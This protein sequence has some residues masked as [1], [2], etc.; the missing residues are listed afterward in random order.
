MK[1]KTLTI[2]SA[3]VLLS[4]VLTA[5]VGTHSAGK[6]DTGTISRHATSVA[7]SGYAGV[8][9]YL[10]LVVLVDNYPY[11]KSLV[12]AWGLSIYCVA[13]GVRFLFDTGPDGSTLRL[14]SEALGINLSSL[15]FIV[16]SHEHGDHVG[17]LKYL[18]KRLKNVRVY[19]PSSSKDLISYV[20][21]LGLEP[22]PVHDTAAL[23]RGVYIIG[24]VYGPPYEVAVAI[25]TSKGF[26]V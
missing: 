10:E 9:K 11:N 1:R 20:S 13:D 15:D 19:V 14:N 26:V 21:E 17:G 12:T 4:A 2:I 22:V 18:A 16:L 24:E 7:A 6:P 23:S 8:V 25:N 5:V 3:I